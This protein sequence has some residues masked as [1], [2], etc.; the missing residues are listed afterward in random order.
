MNI[1]YIVL[2]VL[3]LIVGLYSWKA[4]FSLKDES[5]PSVLP[6]DPID[7]RKNKVYVSQTRDASMFTERSRRLAVLTNP[8]PR[9]SSKGFTNGY[10]DS[11]LTGICFCPKPLCPYEFELDDGGYYDADVCNVLDGMG[12][13]PADF[14]DAFTELCNAVCPPYI[15]ETQEGGN[16]GTDVCNVLDGEGTDVADF[17]GAPDV[18]VC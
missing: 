6:W 2:G 17:G 15:Y 3:S 5:T 7:V 16:V 18:N 14:G 12:S 9:F 13:E 4:Y 11:S 1:N 10:V 8:T